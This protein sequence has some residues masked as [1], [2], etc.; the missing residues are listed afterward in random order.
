MANI[1]IANSLMSNSDSNLLHHERDGRDSGGGGSGSDL[2]FGASL[3]P[4]DA[5]PLSPLPDA[6]LVPVSN[7]NN[8]NTD[9]TGAVSGYTMGGAV[10]GTGTNNNNNN[11]NNNNNNNNNNSNGG[12]KLGM[13]VGS[14][15][16]GNISHNTSDNMVSYSSV[17]DRLRFHDKCGTLVKLSNGART[18][19]RRRPLDE[20]NNGVVMSY[21]A[22]RE[23]ELFEVI[24]ELM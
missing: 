22:L 11:K 15:Q 20:F 18:A 2:P 24:S 12:D 10:G 5:P 1:S 9:G 4:P 16:S 7:N 19:E 13:N 23:N 14:G 3:R 17:S 8:N 6:S 21:R